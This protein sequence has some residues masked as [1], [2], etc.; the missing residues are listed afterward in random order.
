MY[1]E[2]HC[3]DWMNIEGSFLYRKYSMSH[4]IP[5]NN[6]VSN[7]QLYESNLEVFFSF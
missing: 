3:E 1:F 2:N 6:T 5:L 7:L 4:S